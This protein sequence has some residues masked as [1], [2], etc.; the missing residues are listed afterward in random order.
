MAA[1]CGLSIASLEEAE[2]VQAL[3]AS[4]RSSRSLLAIAACARKRFSSGK[5]E[6]TKLVELEEICVKFERHEKSVR[7]HCLDFYNASPSRRTT[8][9]IRCR[10]SELVLEGRSLCCRLRE[11]LLSTY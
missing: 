10:T 9:E 6:P 5:I 3:E 7:D 4:L 1:A 8:L 11:T 2:A